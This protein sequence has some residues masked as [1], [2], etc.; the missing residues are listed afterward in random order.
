MTDL[1]I[2]VLSYNTR[3]T[4]YNCIKTL[5]GSIDNQKTL[6]TEVIVVDNASSDG[7]VEMI[8]AFPVVKLFLSENV[9]FSKGNNR[10]VEI[11]TGRYI[12]YLNSDVMVENVD[13]SELISYLD[14]NLDVGALTVKVNLPDGTIDPASH[15]GFPTLW[16][17]FTYY[18]GLERVSRT[19]KL[20]RNILGGYHLLQYDVNK[21]HEI[22]SPTGAFFL[23][24]KEVVDRLHGFDEN[25]F[26]YGE[27]IDLAFRIKEHKLK[28][29][30]YPK[31]SVVHL[32]YQSGLKTNKNST[33]SK[34]RKHFYEAMKIF[35]KKHYARV[36]PEFVNQAVYMFIDLKSKLR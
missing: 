14:Q 12:L 1:S 5:L 20:G 29:V 8:Q 34:T 27:D 24:R 10:G 33:R 31:Y 19:L 4:T 21:Q 17:S 36:Y 3:E 35:Y 9:G 28:I 11:A 26:M 23:T 16:R 15:R 30:W 18:S 7:S 13:F 22:D 25:F 32:K 6:S 2:I